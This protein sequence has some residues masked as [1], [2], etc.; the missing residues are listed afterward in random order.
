[1]D[2]YPP[3]LI[4]ICNWLQDDETDAILQVVFLR[5]L[6]RFLEQAK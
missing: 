6:S 3:I 5:H 1:M 2:R 4:A